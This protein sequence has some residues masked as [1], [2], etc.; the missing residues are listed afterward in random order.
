M[1]E[2]SNIKQAEN[3]EQ[4]GDLEPVKDDN[5]LDVE[6]W[7]N[8][9]ERID[10]VTLVAETPAQLDMIAS[11]RF[12]SRL[13]PKY[14]RTDAGVTCEGGMYNEDGKWKRKVRVYKGI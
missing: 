13:L 11:R 8:V 9:N 3:S 7:Q 4:D 6:E 2:E 1:T 12:V 10:M 14:N 5:G